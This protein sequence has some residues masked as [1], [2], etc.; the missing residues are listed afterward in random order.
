[1]KR[2]W[3]F[4]LVIVCIFVAIPCYA[5]VYYVD[6]VSG[7]DSRNGLSATV[8]GTSGPWK[9]LSKVNGVNFSPGDYVLFKRGQTW[10]GTGL[11]PKVSGVLGSPIVFDAYGEGE[12]PTL[13]GNGAVGT[14][15]E[16]SSRKWITVRNM[17][18]TKSLN[19]NIRARDSEGI[20]I[21]SCYSESS[22]S[23]HGM[24]WSGSNLNVTNSIFSN[25]GDSGSTH[26]I[27]VDNVTSGTAANVTIK[28]ST[29]DNNAGS[30]IKI[31]S[32]NTGRITNITIDG[33][34]ISNNGNRGIDDYGS[35]GAKYFNNVFWG[36]GIRMN[37][38]SDIY[39]AYNSGGGE[40]YFARNAL[41]YHNTFHHSLAGWPCLMAVSTSTG[42]V[43]RN[44]IFYASGSAYYINVL[45]SGS[46]AAC[47]AN[48]YYGGTP[49]WNYRG[50][51]YT[52]LASWQTGT[53]F[54]KPSVPAKSI[55]A[56]PQFLNVQA[57]DYRLQSTSPCIDVGNA[58]QDVK[59]DFRG[60][61]RPQG[62]GPDAG[63]YEN[64]SGSLSDPA[65]PTGLHRV[66]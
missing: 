6:A 48:C 63:A 46:L 14:M 7:D 62:A 57:H 30:G 58:L 65:A 38:G 27:Y 10:S 66:E 45:G 13:N 51:T 56:D 21:D 64:G 54:D 17:H 53:G 23:G 61:T 39:L 59:T 12:L 47:E 43:I 26:G 60:W 28:G 32:M 11:Q 16:L 22:V 29:F 15:L 3:A 18:I 25:N 49:K 5:S 36:N 4:Y 50:M 42:H 35:D 33:C 37:D 8:T 20:V 34:K 55:V 24:T 19:S 41:I 44:N 31:N 52:S 2:I 40:S 9:T 1:M